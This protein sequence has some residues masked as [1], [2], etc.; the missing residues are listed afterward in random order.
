MK[1]AFLVLA[2]LAT[3]ASAGDREKP[4]VAPPAPAPAPPPAIDTEWSSGVPQDVQDAANKLY[5]EGNVLF[6]QQAHAPALDKY[7]QAIALWDH[8]LIRYNVALTEI[9]L[10]RVVDAADDLDKALRFGAKPFKPELSTGA[11]LSAARQRPCRISRCTCDQP[12]RVLL[13]GK[14]WFDCPG[15]QKLHVTAGE[16]VINQ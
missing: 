12:A 7:K 16:H 14:P 13:D 11:R 5:E 4:P 15:T 2:A 8:P 3:P 10:D 6:A 1:R 9:R